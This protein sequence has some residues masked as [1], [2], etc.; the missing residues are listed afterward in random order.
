MTQEIAYRFAVF[1]ANQLD[2]ERHNALYDSGMANYKKALNC[3]SDLTHEEFS[4]KY[5]RPLTRSL[6]ISNY[7]NA[8]PTSNCT[9]AIMDA[10]NPPESFDWLAKVATPVMNQGECGRDWAIVAAGAV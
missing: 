3:F 9:G 8:P 10:P 2:I 7:E 4:S 6:A 1:V 5:L